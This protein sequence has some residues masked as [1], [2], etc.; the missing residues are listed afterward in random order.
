MIKFFQWLKTTKAKPSPQ[1]AFVADIRNTLLRAAKDIRLANDRHELDGL[2][3]FQVNFGTIIGEVRKIYGNHI[4]DMNSMAMEMVKA[5]GE[6]GEAHRAAA[7]KLDWFMS[8]LRETKG[9]D[10]ATFELMA[11]M[12]NAHD[13]Q[14]IIDG[15][16]IQKCPDLSSINIQERA[17]SL[18]DNFT[19]STHAQQSN[20]MDALIHAGERTAEQLG[21]KGGFI[22]IS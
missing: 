15:R 3:A 9:D 13:W 16:I 1:Q 5:F 21:I 17:A 2:L 12:L 18:I 14:R 22:C 19:K 7:T 10:E 8:K 6:G 11:S 20:I 4:V